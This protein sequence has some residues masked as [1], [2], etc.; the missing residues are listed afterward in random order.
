L[1]NMS[2]GWDASHG[3][4]VIEDY[5]Y[6]SKLKKIAENVGIEINQV[7]N[8]NKLEEHDVIVFNYPE[9][10]FR[11]WEIKKIDEWLRS[12]K[13]IIFTTYYRNIDLTTENVNKVLT[14]L[15][16]PVRVNN[17]VVI[18]PENNAGD[19]MFPIAKYKEYRVVMPCASSIT[20]KNNIKLIVASDKAISNPTGLKNP[21]LG[22]KVKRGGE[23]VVLGTCVFWD[24]YC[25]DLEDNKILSLDLLQ[26]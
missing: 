4:F 20:A 16:I 1:C 25:I 7:S 22:V 15:R 13:K 24:N 8:F 3:E 6:F 9:K 23:L 18:D 19:E 2:V 5:Y 10:R 11:T 21:V 14:K 17:D 12:G 26:Y